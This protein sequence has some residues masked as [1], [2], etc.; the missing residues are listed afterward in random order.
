MLS[1]EGIERLVQPVLEQ[2]GLVLHGAELRKEGRELVLRLTV[3]RAK[4]ATPRDGVTIDELVRANDEVG[5]LLDLENPIEDKYRLTIESP[6]IERDLNTWR[7]FQYAVGERVR[8]VTRGELSCVIEGI[9][10]SA[11]AE[12]H[13]LEIQTAEETKRVDVSEIKSGRTVF[14]WGDKGGES[15]K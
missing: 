1:V 9:L 3:D 8:I 15:R 12:T 11:D 7:H 14:D 5:A 13:A 4:K 6:G 10:S 2:M